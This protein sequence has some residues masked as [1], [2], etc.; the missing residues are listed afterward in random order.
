MIDCNGK[1]RS[2]VIPKWVG[3]D[4]ANNSRELTIPRKSN[5]K[6]NSFTKDQIK[7]QLDDFSENPSIFKAAD[8][9]GAAIVIND[10]DTATTMA[11]HIVDRRG[12][13]KPT[14]NLAEKILNLKTV[15]NNAN[16]LLNL[17]FRIANLKRAILNGPHNSI[18]WMELARQ[19]TIKGQKNKAR[20]AAQVALNL[21]PYNRYIVRSGARFFIHIGE[22]DTALHYIQKSLSGYNDPWIKAI[23]VSLGQKLKFKIKKIRDLLP[24][25]PSFDILFHYSE[26]FESCG[27]LEL[28]SGNTKRA[29]GIFKTAWKNPTESVVRHGEWVIRNRFPHLEES[30]GL[31][32]NNSS[33]AVSFHLFYNYEFSRALE[34]ATQWELEEPYSAGPY[35][36]GSHIYDL[37]GDFQKAI[38]TAKRGLSANPKHFS[39]INNLSYSL[40]RNNNIDEA[41]KLLQKFSPHVGPQHMM[42]YNATSGLLEFKKGHIKNG[43]FLYKKSIDECREMGSLEYHAKA[44]LNLAIAEVEQ[45]TTESV[46]LAKIALDRSKSIN[47]PTAR[48]LSKTLKQKL[49]KR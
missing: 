40:L 16:Q 8:I 38:E 6:I 48:I 46:E 24:K 11:K 20:K 45:N 18:V 35:I 13:E 47:D 27:M 31:N 14:I 32:F 34:K 33:E 28:E 42:F 37:L 29:K 2:L 25:D 21:A 49:D 36:L 22:F 43:R 44:L 10:I 4:R 3:F 23:E 7:Q 41:E 5:F 9:M 17:D 12:L 15:E 26:L 39:L 30:S 19:Y 1:K